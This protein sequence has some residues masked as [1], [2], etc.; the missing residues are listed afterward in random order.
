MTARLLLQYSALLLAAVLVGATAG[1]SA[2]I[3]KTKSVLADD[4]VTPAID[5]DKLATDAKLREAD[6][7]NRKG[8]KHNLE[9]IAVAM[10]NYAGANGSSIV[11]D[12]RG[13]DGKSLLSWR[14]SLLP[15][16]AEADAGLVPPG[17]SPPAPYGALYKEFKLDEPWDSKH[18]LTLLAKMPKVFVSPR[19]TVKGKGYT[20]YQV[21]S[22]P[23]ALF[24][25]GKSKYNIG[26]VPDGTS[27]TIFV[28]ETS[29]AVPWTKPADIPFD[30]D[31]AVPDFGKAYGSKPLAAMMDGSARVLDLKKILPET[32][33]N[34]I[35]PDD[36]NVL[37][38]DWNE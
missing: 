36:G 8:S 18:N 16:L 30:K 29:K 11:T 33:K 21:F 19:V 9:Q 32:L 15:Y 4:T 17:A 10:H 20:V 34:A 6:A 5:L 7:R 37:G 31:K 1:V 23:G 24:N 12:I 13:K 22:G 3:G 25:A 28:V 14:V 2:P 27:N 38:A 26:N 35:M